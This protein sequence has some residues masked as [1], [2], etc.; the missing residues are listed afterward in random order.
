MIKEAKRPRGQGARKRGPREAQGLKL[1]TSCGHNTELLR[2][3]VTQQLHDE[4]V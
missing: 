2:K 4:Y 1:R 3:T